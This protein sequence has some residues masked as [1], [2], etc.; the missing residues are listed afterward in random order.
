MGGP[1]GD[2]SDD[3]YSPGAFR[4]WVPLLGDVIWEG[5]AS[6]ADGAFHAYTCRWIDDQRIGYVRVPHYEH[7][8]GAIDGLR[9]IIARFEADTNALV[10]DQVSNPGGRMFQMY[11]V[12]ALLTDAP[13]A[14]PMHQ[15][16]IRDDDVDVAEEDVA[17]GETVSPERLAWAQFVLA[18]RRAGRGTPGNLS[19]PWYVGGVTKILPDTV[20]YTKQIV[21]LIDKQTAS[22]AEFLAAILQDN[23]RARLFGGAT[24]GA[25]GC[26]RRSDSLRNYDLD[27][28]YTRTIVHRTNGPPI[29][30]LGV[31]PDVRYEVTVDDLSSGY[32]GYRRALLASLH[33]ER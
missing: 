27:F 18:E 23:R 19:T 25:G 4:S 29:E 5:P 10:L 9:D 14:L 2:D 31:L 6:L 12:L 26:T 3:P 8:E 1:T 24:A 30:N 16:T 21:V 33:P 20:R 28:S 17:D 22:A 7:D 13:L 15:I 11:A 32:R